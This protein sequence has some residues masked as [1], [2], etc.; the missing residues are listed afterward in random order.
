MNPGPL[1]FDAKTHTYSDSLGPLSGV[2]S[3]LSGAG[4][5]DYSFLT[6]S[7]R[8]HVLDRGK[9]AHTLT[10]YY[11]QDDLVETNID[12]QIKPYLESY[13]QFKRET[14]SLKILGI[15][16]F[17]RHPLQRYAGK[18]DR[19]VMI[20]GKLCILDLK[21]GELQPWTALQLE[22]YRQAWEIEGGE[23]I[24]ARYGL[25]LSKTG[26]FNKKKDFIKYDDPSDAAAWLSVVTLARWKGRNFK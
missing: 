7:K 16:K 10:E 5:I 26:I 14:P 21:T 15:E 13:K 20:E 4:L 11:D 9:K 12:P 22:G 6:E 8:D 24:H 17:V 3:L 1:N 18:F 2:T 19:L 25:H 23:K